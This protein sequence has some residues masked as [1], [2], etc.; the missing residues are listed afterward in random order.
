MVHKWVVR[1]QRRNNELRRNKDSFFTFYDGERLRRILM[2]K[3]V[4][5][6]LR[7]CTSL[8]V[9]DLQKC[10]DNG[11]LSHRRDLLTTET[12]LKPPHLL[13]RL[14]TGMISV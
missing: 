14:Q 3:L 8:T 9:C 10:L 5:G 12:T 13:L 4:R 6:L 11:T 1:H 2:Y 7:Q